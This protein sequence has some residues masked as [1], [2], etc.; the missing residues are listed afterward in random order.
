MMH[1]IT[2]DTAIR[3]NFCMK[4]IS[5]FVIILSIAFM[6]AQGCKGA[7]EGALADAARKGD[8][9]EV[10]KYIGK[11]ADVNAQWFG[12]TPLQVAADEGKTEVIELLL[13][14]GADINIKS[15]FDKTALDFAEVKG[16]RKTIDLLKSKGAKK[17]AE[18]K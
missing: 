5:V 1:S 12:R 4:K 10:E 13:K 17:A 2:Y 6:A 3:R 8:V 7:Y 15:K 11:G 14:K 18:L 16:D 9:Q